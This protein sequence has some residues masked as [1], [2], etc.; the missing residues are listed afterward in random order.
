LYCFFGGVCPIGGTY[1]FG[2]CAFLNQLGAAETLVNYG[3]IDSVAK[4][5]LKKMARTDPYYKRNR[6][7]ICSFYVKGECKRG[8]ECPYR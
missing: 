3:K 1:L 2:G 5:A 6:A 7:H 8:E 4:D